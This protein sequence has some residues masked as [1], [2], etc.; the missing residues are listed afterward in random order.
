MQDQIYLIL[1]WRG[2][3]QENA[4]ECELDPL[5]DIIAHVGSME[6]GNDFSERNTTNGLN[7]AQLVKIS[8]CGKNASAWGCQSSYSEK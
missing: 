8:I 3:S 7:Y 1:I 4:V 2:G 5:D 6:L